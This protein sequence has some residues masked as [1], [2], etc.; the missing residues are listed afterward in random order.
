MY[1]VATP[2]YHA[3]ELPGDRGVAGVHKQL[4]PIV[5]R[6][7]YHWCPCSGRD[8]VD[9]PQG[10][11]IPTLPEY[12]FVCWGWDKHSGKR[13]CGVRWCDVKLRAPSTNCSLPTEWKMLHSTQE[14][15]VGSAI[16]LALQVPVH[17]RDQMHVIHRIR[18][19]RLINMPNTRMMH[20]LDVIDALVSETLCAQEERRR[21]TREA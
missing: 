13:K 19:Y 18:V 15:M 3:Q 21:H 6:M 10:L 9:S 20:A 7:V 16:Q 8:S 17:S 1:P 2:A 5:L 11:R 4:T 14:A 12:R